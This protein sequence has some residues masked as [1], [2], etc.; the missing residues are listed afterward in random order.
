M[1]EPGVGAI[2]HV[3]DGTVAALHV[4]MR[5]LCGTGLAATEARFAHR[6][7]A[8]AAPFRQFSGSRCASTPS[9]TPSV[10]HAGT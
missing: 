3:G 2:D 6:M 4:A 8:D 9:V 1:Y 7:P 5:E 10:F